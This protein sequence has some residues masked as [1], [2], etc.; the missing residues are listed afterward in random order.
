MVLTLVNTCMILINICM[1]SLTNIDSRYERVA[2][3]ESLLGIDIDEVSLCP[4]GE[5]TCPLP[6]PRARRAVLEGSGEGQAVG[7]RVRYKVWCHVDE[8]PCGVSVSYCLPNSTWSGV[9]PGC[10]QNVWRPPYLENTARDD[11]VCLGVYREY[12]MFHWFCVWSMIQ[13]RF[14]LF[15]CVSY[16]LQ[17]AF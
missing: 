8:R 7:S 16:N 4:Q 15:L 2:V 10:C 14:S 12:D 17:K 13:V 9:S 5:L 6:P 3:W 1:K 11:P